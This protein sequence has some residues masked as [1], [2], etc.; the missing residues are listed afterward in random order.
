M[1]YF[2]LACLWFL[3]ISFLQ[4]GFAAPVTYQLDPNHTYIIWQVN[5]FGFSQVSG[6][7]MAEGTLQFDDAKP[8]ASVLSVSVPM[9]GLVTGIPR[10]DETLRGANFFNVGQFPAAQF[11][12]TNVIVLAKDSGQV[13]GKLTMRG[14]TKEVLLKVKLNHAGLHPYYHKQAMGFSA[15]GELKRSDFGLRGYLP[16]VGDEVK[17]TIQA[18][19]V[20]K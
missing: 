19:A 10:F 6:K 20:V 9:N 4:V 17:L 1:R 18:E 14:V 12:S 5:H 16:G 8:S 2:S 11:V 13:M 15:E 7:F 3:L